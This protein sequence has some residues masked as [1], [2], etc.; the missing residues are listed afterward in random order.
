MQDRET[1]LRQQLSKCKKSKQNFKNEVKNYEH[2][3]SELVEQVA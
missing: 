2:K 3:Y 1:V